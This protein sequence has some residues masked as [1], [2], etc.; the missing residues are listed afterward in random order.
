MNSCKP[1]VP[2]WIMP[3]NRVVENFDPQITRF[4]VVIIDEAS[5]S[6]LMALI[7][8]YLGRKAVVVGDHEQ[9]SPLAVG[10]NAAVVNG[11]IS[12][13]LGSIPNGVLWNG[14][15]SVYDLARQ[16]FGDT[17]MLVEHFR[18]APDIIEFSNALC[19]E[20]KIKPLR[21]AGSAAVRPATIPYRVE[22]VAADKLN[23]V[24]ATAVASL[25][26]AACDQPEYENATVGVI[27]L[28][29]DEQAIEIERL[30][31]TRLA[32]EEYERRR[33]L[34]G[35]AAQFQGDERDVV[36]LSLVDSSPDGEPLPTREASLFRQ[37]F[38]VAASR[39]RDQL[40]VVHSLDPAVHLRERDLRRRLIEHAT[41][42]T[43]RSQRMAQREVRVKSE[44]E[45][46]VMR[47]LNA[48]GY[49]VHP[50][51]Q[52][53]HY[54]IDLV[55]LGGGRRL[56]VECDGDRYHP[57]EKLAE[58][59]ERQA[60]LERLGWTFVRIRG[61]R[62][63]R[64]PG[65][66]MEP[67]FARLEALRIPPT[68]NAGAPG[69][70][71]G[72]EELA[73]RVIRRAAEIR[74]RW[75]ND[76]IGVPSPTERRA[77]RG[78]RRQVSSGRNDM[79]QGITSGNAENAAGQAPYE[80]RPDF[81]L[82]VRPSDASSAGCSPEF[83]NPAEV[84]ANAPT[85]DGDPII[86]AK[87]LAATRRSSRAAGKLLRDGV[88]CKQLP[89][90]DATLADPHC[91]ACG[92]EAPPAIDTN[93]GVVVAC[94]DETCGLRERVD[95]Q[96][97]QQLADRVHARCHAC[98]GSVRSLRGPFSN[99]LKCTACGVNNSWVGVY[100]SLELRDRGRGQDEQPESPPGRN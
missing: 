62:F 76:P 47:R 3:L 77:W 63:F 45:R 22:G 74:M 7:A 90:V 65:A 81:P 17:V 25:V 16:S 99:Y 84:E 18:C 9:V 32:P 34:C 21:E 8:L 87:A 19:Y 24:E 78:R 37:R 46:E 69:R 91:S 86:A 26:V 30:L 68:V 44:F 52:V 5:Q 50:Q 98:G 31:R 88:I 1:A 97:L 92:A 42:P 20:G 15:F 11:L 33:V 51:W 49:D 43:A 89:L 80:G 100:E 71:Q 27:S 59:M 54:R 82:S 73:S 38:D 14:Q 48:E 41:D 2:V 70:P 53:G 83:G 28:V 23:A 58:D 36:F 4:D 85:A 35:N 75:E 61:S 64:E 67:V 55:V 6:D 40:W 94:G 10:Q 66:A 29:G 39:A 79:T 96:V 56:A 12:Q 57:Q 93:E 95:E 72:S 13:H 60:I